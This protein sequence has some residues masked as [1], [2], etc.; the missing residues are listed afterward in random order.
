MAMERK[1]EMNTQDTNA[2]ATPLAPMLDALLAKTT[3]ILSV[4]NPQTD[5]VLIGEHLIAE[6][7]VTAS[8]GRM[9]SVEG[10]IADV[11]AL[12]ALRDRKRL[13]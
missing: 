7:V 8:A 5:P 3:G 13:N 11:E 12:L 1:N 10:L 2:P 4:R 9:P 6:I